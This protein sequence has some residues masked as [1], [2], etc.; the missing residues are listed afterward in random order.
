MNAAQPIR[1]TTEPKPRPVYT[2]PAAML[3]DMIA[4][5]QEENRLM[6]QICGRPVG[7][8]TGAT[9]SDLPERIYA[10]VADNPGTTGPEI[11]K[12]IQAESGNVRNRLSTL[13]HRGKLKRWK[14][15]DAYHTPFRYEVAR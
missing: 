10:F 3:E 9:K 5:A 15:D 11:M 1:Y 4:Q 2:D 12:G 8:P 14:D 7:R 6:R 13:V